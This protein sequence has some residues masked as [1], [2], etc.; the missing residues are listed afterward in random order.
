MNIGI[1][2]YFGFSGTLSG[3][4]QRKVGTSHTTS[5]ESKHIEKWRW[6]R[7]RGNLKNGYALKKEENVWNKD[8]LKN[9][10]GQKKT[11][12]SPKTKDDP[13]NE[14][15]SKNEDNPKKED[16]PKKGE[17][18]QNEDLHKKE[19]GPKNKENPKNR[20]KNLFVTFYRDKPTH[21]KTHLKLFTET[22]LL[23]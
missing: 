19:D 20:V 23:M 6:P 11:K 18:L 12:Q 5:E 10:D 13:K 17:D 4:Y 3:H 21:F 2:L 8:N 22:N 1:Y 15:H 14:D 16:I 9:E 7:M